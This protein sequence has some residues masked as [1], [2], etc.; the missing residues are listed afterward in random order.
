MKKLL[1]A[2]LSILTA[3]TVSAKDDY[4]K[5]A[6][7]DSNLDKV[8]GFVQAGH[9]I[10][11]EKKEEY[12]DLA[13]QKVVERETACKDVTYGCRSK[14]ANLELI[15]SMAIFG[16]SSK[17]LY[18]QYR[19]VEKSWKGEAVFGLACAN[20]FKNLIC[21]CKDA[22]RKEESAAK[23]KDSKKILELV[24]NMTALE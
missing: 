22:S 19:D 5:K 13:R 4:I 24:Q 8:E 1:V 9:P 21:F 7:A 14:L 2:S 12:V 6:I 10:F 23:L 16:F 15:T 11:W 3:L 17:I 20:L 18:N